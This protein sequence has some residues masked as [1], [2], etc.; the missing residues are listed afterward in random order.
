MTTT[1]FGDAAASQNA[2]YTAD[3]YII[4]DGTEGFHTFLTGETLTQ[5]V[6]TLIHKRILFFFYRRVCCCLTVPL[7]CW[8]SRTPRDR[9]S[10]GV[11]EEI[12]VSIYAYY[13]SY[14]RKIYDLKKKKVGQL[15]NV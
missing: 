2:Y 1:F 3:T 15:R 10:S 5:Q 8:C 14:S 7:F 9:D 11:F 6:Y 4:A 12:Y 13:S